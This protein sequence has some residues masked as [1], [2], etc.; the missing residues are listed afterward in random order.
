MIKDV[1]NWFVGLNA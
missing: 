1:R